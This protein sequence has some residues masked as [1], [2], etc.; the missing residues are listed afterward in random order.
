MS[1]VIKGAV[2]S[3]DGPK[4]ITSILDGSI[5]LPPEERDSAREKVLSPEEEAQ[6]NALA[7]MIEESRRKAEQILHE[8]E[9][10]RCSVLAAAQTEADKIIADVK[11]EAEAAAEQ[12]KV[13]VYE[14]FS[15]KGYEEGHDRGYKAGR[16]EMVELVE[17]A[18][19]KA[20]HTIRTAELEAE[21]ALLNSEKKMVELTL[22]IAK[23]IIADLVIN[24]PQVILPQVQAALKKVKDQNEIVVKVSPHDYD[25]VLM[26]K[27]E[28]RSMLS[29]DSKLEI[30]VD[31]KIEAGGCIV[32][33]NNGNVDARLSTK[34][35]AVIKAIQEAA[36]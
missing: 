13:S 6:K 4:I 7:L 5:K 3:G 28:F 35:E 20:Q 24:S 33:S 31:N 19:E 25:F 23:K 36:G 30:A 21:K 2:I 17:Q 16:E 22:A 32:E 11:A 15:K 9:Q 1:R 14:E 10:Q 27:D 8:A 29:S 34:M 12:M 26:A 18:N